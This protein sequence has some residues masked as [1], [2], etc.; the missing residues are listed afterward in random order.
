MM[1]GNQEG[2]LN[3]ETYTST[4]WSIK[5]L[6]A[7]LFFQRKEKNPPFLVIFKIFML[8]FPGLHFC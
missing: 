1:S 6:M 3:S 4:H 5:Y 8:F 7:P 2:V